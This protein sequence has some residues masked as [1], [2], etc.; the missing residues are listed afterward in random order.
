MITKQNLKVNIS[1]TLQVGPLNPAGHEHANEEPL[2]THEAPF[3]QGFD[4]QIF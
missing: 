1:A 2:A 3:K 4:E